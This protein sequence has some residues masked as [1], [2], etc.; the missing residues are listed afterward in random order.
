MTK[1]RLTKIRLWIE[2]VSNLDLPMIPKSGP[3]VLVKMEDKVPT[4]PINLASS[5][6][7]ERAMDIVEEL[8]DE[9]V[10]EVSVTEPTKHEDHYS[11]NTKTW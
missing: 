9:A 3:L 7:N 5:S 2:D 11:G 6:D 4:T 1:I 8:K 10:K